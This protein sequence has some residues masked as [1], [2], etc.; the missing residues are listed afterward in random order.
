MTWFKKIYIFTFAIMVLL[1]AGIKPGYAYT[2]HIVGEQTIDVTDEEKEYLIGQGF[3]EYTSDE[4]TIMQIIES[5]R[6]SSENE[7]TDVKMYPLIESML[8]SVFS[9]GS[10]GTIGYR[11]MLNEGFAM[12]NDTFETMTESGNDIATFY[13]SLKGIGILIMTMYFIVG[14]ASKDYAQ[15]FGK[16]TIE[17]LIKPFTKFVLAL[18]FLMNIEYILKMFLYLSQWCFFVASDLDFSGVVASGTGTAAEVVDYKKI[19]LDAVGFDSEGSGL[20]ASVKNIMAQLQIIVAFIFP[21]VISLI[22]SVFGIWVIYTRTVNIILTAIM[23]PLSMSDL[24]SEHPLRETK[25]WNYIKEFAGLCFQSVVIVAAYAVTAAIMSISMQSLNLS[26]D[27]AMGDLMIVA[28][29]I[30]VYKAVQVGVVMGSANRAKK[31]MAAV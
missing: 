2:W 24:Y 11:D 7:D 26:S 3:N 21:W 29:K 10:G 15:Q 25:A 17:M 6:E 19:I 30:S 4:S 28:L 8:D 27:M 23:A 1:I 16:P 14:L 13:Y 5:Y 18:F 9:D 22:S 31:V 20:V 12:I